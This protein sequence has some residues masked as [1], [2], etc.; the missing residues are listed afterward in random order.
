[1]RRTLRWTAFAF[2]CLISGW[3]ISSLYDFIPLNMP[4]GVYIFIRNC[5]SL[6]QLNILANTDDIETLALLLYWFVTSVLLAAF[7]L[8]AKGWIWPRARGWLATRLGAAS[9]IGGWLAACGGV[10]FIAPMSRA[11]TSLNSD[12]TV[13]RLLLEYW[14]WATFAV[15]AVL[16]VCRRVANSP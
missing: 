8:A 5:L 13:E 11:I 6:F 15:C 10:A 4:Y 3:Y 1:M 2:F 16:I 12:E 14:A 9:I 7:V